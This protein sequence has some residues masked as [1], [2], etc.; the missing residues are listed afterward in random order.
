METVEQIE[1]KF[2][3]KKPKKKGLLIGGIITGIIVMALALVY[4][5][6]LTKPQF[7]FGKAIDKIF[8]I[9]SQ[10]YDSIK[11]NTEIKVAIDAEDATYDEYL[12]EIEKVTIKA[13]TQLDISD[14]KEIVE[15]GLEY[16]N[17]EVADAQL[18]YNDG[19][20]YAYLDGLFDKYI[21]ID[22]DE[23]AKEQLENIFENTDVKNEK[24]FLDAFKDELKAQI[25]EKGKYEK[26]KTTIEVEDEEVK[27]TKNT[28]IVKDKEAYKILENVMK[29]LGKNEKLLGT[30][31]KSKRK[32]FKEAMEQIASSIEETATDDDITF[33]I[34]LYTK[35]LLN[36]KLVAADVEIYSEYDESTVVMRVVKENEGVYTYNIFV[37]IIHIYNCSQ[38]LA[39]LYFHIHPLSL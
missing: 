17:E 8:E 27:V 3:V 31:E 21:E 20:M 25:K 14:K 13:G 12:K 16:D 28:Y 33:K 22:M 39:F 7:I 1:Q 18:Y 5:L 34:S 35:G 2:N 9:D 38:R 23:E 10:Y 24:I 29:N 11:V 37:I 30:I 32:E 6:V 4:F 15:L 19:N 26:K 36:N